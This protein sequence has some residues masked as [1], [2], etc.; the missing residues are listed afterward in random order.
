MHVSGVRKSTHG[1]TRAFH[2]I[3]MD[4]LAHVCKR[5]GTHTPFATALPA[6]TRLSVDNFS[7]DLFPKWE[8]ITLPHICQVG[9]E[10]SFFVL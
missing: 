10:I 7:Q 5:D 9:D 3:R 2:F 8:Y 1:S 6:M 4:C